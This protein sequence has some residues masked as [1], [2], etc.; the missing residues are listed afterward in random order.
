MTN[1]NLKIAAESNRALIPEPYDEIYAAYGFECLEMVVGAFGKQNVYVPSLRTVLYE[2]VMA[3]VR[4]EVA[5][6]ALP[7]E[8]I[9]KK[10]GFTPRH[11]RKILNGK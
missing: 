7:L 8:G 9:A 6:R 3:E 5:G 1:A 2:C 4:K 10:Y 11:L